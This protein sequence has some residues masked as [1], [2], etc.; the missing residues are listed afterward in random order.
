MTQSGDSLALTRSH[1]GAAGAVSVFPVVAGM[2]R[3]SHKS[4]KRR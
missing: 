2:V 4:E 1:A 3:I